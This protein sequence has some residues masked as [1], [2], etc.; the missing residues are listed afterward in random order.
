MP[1]NLQP[2]FAQETAK[3]SQNQ[4]FRL[5]EIQYPFI[6]NQ[7][8]GGVLY[9]VDSNYDV[10]FGG[11]LYTRF[12]LKFNGAT[13]SSDGS[14]NPATLTVAN[15]SR[16]IMYFVEKCKGLR[17]MRVKIKSAYANAL[18]YL[19]ECH[20]DGTVTSS[21]NPSADSQ[22]YI[23][24]E[25]I[26]DN[27]TAN[28]TVVAF[29]LYPIIDLDIKLPRRRYMVD[30]CYWVYKDRFTCRYTGPL[31]SC[32]KNF[33][34]C[35]LHRGVWTNVPP[36]AIL[37]LHKYA[38]QAS[39]QMDWTGEISPLPPSTSRGAAVTGWELV[40]HD[41]TRL[42]IIGIAFDIPY[43]ATVYLASSY[44]GDPVYTTDF[45]VETPKGNESN[46]GG[47]PGING[48]RRIFL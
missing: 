22:A 9:F 29:Q 47:F 1:R 5:V 26:I 46:F 32:K 48:N 38:V 44:Q 18:D 41:I 17:S 11:Q 13:A 40:I 37:N 31:E 21:T 36:G 4:L 39:I 25:F 8:Q 6:D 3:P 45:R 10:T 43:S 7:N 23:E 15:V 33:A 2:L 24:D 12:P 30:T 42:P 27:Y 14:V 16:E 35:K 20:E 28:E 34:D 19:Y